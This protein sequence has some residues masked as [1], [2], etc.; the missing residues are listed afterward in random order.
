MK[1]KLIFLWLIILFIGL[2]FWIY[3]IFWSISFDDNSDAFLLAEWKLEKDYKPD[4]WQAKNFVEANNKFAV[5]LYHY[6]W[7]SEKD[8]NLFFSPISIESAFA[9]LYEWSD[10]K[11]KKEMEDVLHF[12]GTS[13]TRLWIKNTFEIIN[14]HSNGYKL[15]IADAVWLQKDFK[16][17]K[18][19]LN[20]IAKYYYGEIYKVDFVWTPW[21]AV[22]LINTRVSKKTNWKI[23]TI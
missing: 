14:T 22:D 7:N 15:R 18:N 8:K 20:S 6:L 3:K 5:D 21:E 16:V 9:M 17:F 23:P 4:Y 2:G 11:T 1:S 13:W 10:W 19:Y 12:P